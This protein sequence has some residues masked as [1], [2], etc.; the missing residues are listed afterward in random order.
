M[1]TRAPSRRSIIRS[2]VGAGALGLTAPAWAQSAFMLNQADVRIWMPN[3]SG[4]PT[5]AQI[6][7]M[8]QAL[9]AAGGGYGYIPPGTHVLD[10]PVDLNCS[11]VVICGAGRG[12]WSDGGN[13]WTPG[14]RLY[15][16]FTGAPL[17]KIRTPYGATV[18]QN[19]GAG[20]QNIM[21][22]AGTHADQALV[23][24]SVSQIV[25]EGVYCTGAIGNECVLIKSGVSYTDM[26]ESANIQDSLI[27]MFVRQIDTSAEKLAHCVRIVGS[28]NANLS[29][30]EGPGKGVRITAQHWTGDAVRIE[31]AD[32]NDI[33]LRAFSAGAGRALTA[34]GPRSGVPVGCEFNFFKCS[35]NGAIYAEGTDTSG[36]THGISNQLRRDI[37]NSTPSGTHGTGSSWDDRS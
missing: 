19:R 20:L 18:S 21:L 15:A 11:R 14:T 36:V 12:Q 2:L 31:S 16:G 30:N 7:T 24:D 6:N 22:D 27:S 35:T 23:I 9:K 37:G 28:S 13:T 4:S 8:I 26:A 3:P 29:E 1:R 33:W 34:C 32:A 5:A 17:F 25:V 10:E